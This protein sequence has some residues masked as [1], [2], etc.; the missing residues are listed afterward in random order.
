MSIKNKQNHVSVRN[1]LVNYVINHQYNPPHTYTHHS[2]INKRT[3]MAPTTHVACIIIQ[4]TRIVSIPEL[5]HIAGTESHLY[6]Y[7]YFEVFVCTADYQ[8]T[9]R[10]HLCGTHPPLTT[11][12][13]C[14]LP[15]VP[16]FIWGIQV[17]LLWMILE[18]WNSISVGIWL[19]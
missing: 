16:V 18:A 13:G 19:K 9:Q 17:G 12:V 1:K 14:Y 4:S 15:A 5:R 11:C 8:W 6:F 3:K 7:L 2:Q 10:A